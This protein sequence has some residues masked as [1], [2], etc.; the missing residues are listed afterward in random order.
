MNIASGNRQGQVTADMGLA[1]RNAVYIY[2]A[3]DDEAN[4]TLYLTIRQRVFIAITDATYTLTLVLPSVVEAAGMIF[5]V[6]IQT[7][8]GQ[9]LTVTDDA[10]DTDFDDVTFADVNDRGLFYSDGIHWHFIDTGGAAAA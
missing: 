9:N 5:S 7:D 1:D 10:D 3:S 6:A 4:T 2:D 8:G